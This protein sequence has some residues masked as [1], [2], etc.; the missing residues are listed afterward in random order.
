[1]INSMI[2]RFTVRNYTD[3]EIDEK[4]LNEL[5]SV[6]CRSSNTGNMQLYSIIVTREKAV[7]E[8]LAPAHF[9][10]PQIYAPVV[11]TFCA[12]VNRYSKWCEQRGADAGVD[13]IEAF[14][15]S[16]IDTIIAAQTFCVAAEEEG[17]GICYLGT[18]TYNAGQIIKT[19]NLPKLVIPLATI[20]VGYPAPEEIKEGK[21]S[22][23][24]PL[25]GIVHNEKYSEYTP[26]DIDKIYK[27][28]ESLEENKEYVKIN[29][30]DNLAKVF[31]EIRYTRKDNEFFS[32]EFI[33]A[34]KEQGFL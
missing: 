31:A 9:N 22:E 2:S 16:A 4:L 20:T 21:Q 33:S 34:I 11:L 32:K 24:L 15:Y 8:E 10:Q 27:E 5:L 6:T 13:N 17:L 26:Q 29:K 3:K 19:L 30:K 25:E 28:K 23:R 12:D 18:T 14:T 1:M 7:K